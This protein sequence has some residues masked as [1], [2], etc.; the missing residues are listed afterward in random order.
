MGTCIEC[1]SVGC[2]GYGYNTHT[3]YVGSVVYRCA[4]Y[5]N[6]SG[7]YR[8]N[9]TPLRPITITADP[10]I[11]ALGGDFRLNDDPNGGAIL[12]G[13]GLGVYGQIDSQ[14]IGA[15]QAAKQLGGAIGRMYF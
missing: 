12:K 6:A 4:G 1:V 10:F 3:T 2:S 13:A 9:F 8:S 15:V 5:N 14:D 11:D 7:T